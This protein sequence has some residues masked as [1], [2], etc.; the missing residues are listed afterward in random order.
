MTTK[1]SSGGE[2]GVRGKSAVAT[3]GGVAVSIILAFSLMV[4]F[5]K[6]IEVKIRGDGELGLVG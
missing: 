6:T 3:G 5:I 1:G 4:I 2:G